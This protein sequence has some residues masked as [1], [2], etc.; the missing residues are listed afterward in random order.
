MFW[1]QPAN[2]LR[3][4]ID[5]SLMRSLLTSSIK[6]GHKYIIVNEAL[7]ASD[8]ELYDQL[9]DFAKDNY[10]MVCYEIEMTFPSRV[11]PLLYYDIICYNILYLLRGI[12]MNVTIYLEDPLAHELAHW[13]KTS[14]QNRNA[15]IREAIHEWIAHRKQ[16]EWP[17]IILKFKGEKN[18]PAFENYRDELQTPKE[19][20]LA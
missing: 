4:K 17:E 16:R 13:S 9:I 15:I 6:N 3:L 19:D 5:D 20:P 12:K 11:S 7:K 10:L 2:W 18:F 8:P 1:G 14:G